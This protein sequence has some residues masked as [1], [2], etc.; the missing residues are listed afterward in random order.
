MASAERA[1]TAQRR[2][3]QQ[4]PR[5]V[6]QPVAV[7]VFTVFA[8]LLFHFVILWA[9][10]LITVGEHRT[11][12]VVDDVENKIG[13]FSILVLAKACLGDFPLPILGIPLTISLSGAWL[14]LRELR[15]QPALLGLGIGTLSA[16]FGPLVVHNIF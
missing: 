8:S 13:I 5:T 4:Q 9:Y 14:T 1:N 10:A 15:L 11:I 2:C 12:S 7:A 16:T 6:P 3:E